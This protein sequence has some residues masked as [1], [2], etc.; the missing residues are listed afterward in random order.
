[1]RVSFLDSGSMSDTVVCV[2][3]DAM[4]STLSSTGRVLAVDHRQDDPMK[5]DALGCHVHR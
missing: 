5:F 3:N 4:S 1:M 2:S